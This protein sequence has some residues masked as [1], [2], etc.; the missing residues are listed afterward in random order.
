MKSALVSMLGL[1]LVVAQTPNCSPVQYYSSNRGMCMAKKTIGAYCNFVQKCVDGSSCIG[2]KCT[3]GA[4]GAGGVVYE[5]SNANTGVCN[6]PFGT[7][8]PASCCTMLSA[9][10]TQGCVSA[11]YSDKCQPTGDPQKTDW[12]DCQTSGYYCDPVDGM[13]RGFFDCLVGCQRCESVTRAVSPGVCYRGLSGFFMTGSNNCAVCPKGTAAKG[14]GSCMPLI[15]RDLNLI[16]SE[17]RQPP[18]YRSAKGLL[19]VYLTFDIGTYEDAYF[20]CPDGARIY[21]DLTVAPTFVVFPGDML[22][23]HFMN[24]LEPDKEEAHV[25]HT[26]ILIGVNTTNLHVHGLHVSS[27]QPEDDVLIEIE[28][29]QSF[30]YKFIIHKDHMPGHHWYH[31]HRHGASALHTAHAFGS[32]VIETDYS[33]AGTKYGFTN[34]PQYLAGMRKL[35]FTMHTPQFEANR[36]DV[37]RNDYSIKFET[38]NNV[39]R[40]M[41]DNY[42]AKEIDAPLTPCNPKFPGA[43]RIPY[44]MVNGQHEPFIRMHTGEPVELMMLAAEWNTQHNVTIEGCTSFILSKDGIN[45]YDAPR[46]VRSSILPPGARSGTVIV[47]PQAGEYGIFDEQYE[48]PVLLATLKVVDRKIYSAKAPRVTAAM[49]TALS[50]LANR[51]PWYLE[52]LTTKPSASFKKN[53]LAYATADM[54]DTAN[55]MMSEYPWVLKEMMY[56]AY[57]DAASWGFT[58]QTTFMI[59]KVMFTTKAPQSSFKLDDIVETTLAGPLAHP[60]HQHVNPFQVMSVFPYPGTT[61]IDP[62]NYYDNWYKVKDWQ[63]T[64][65][66]ATL[67]DPIMGDSFY[68]A[69]IRWKVADFDNEVMVLHCH[70]LIHEDH[71]MMTWYAIG[72]PSAPNSDA[73]YVPHPQYDATTG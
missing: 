63:D 57:D 30:E 17:L 20:H 43:E 39:R 8:A 4:N 32:I 45:L 24:A 35:I 1:A 61:T 14:D 41:R 68:G 60:H 67:R 34:L 48:P 28:G 6:V 16:G 3:A 62:M 12:H 69:T 55:N 42:L 29:G 22:A 26:N 9:N 58:F 13:F 70:I 21:N 38:I 15:T 31:P 50:P 56:S 19:D 65:Q 66:M 53:T 23:I 25:N 33:S 51:W 47:C 72:D 36:D 2:N 73:D 64:F 40:I 52:D 10:K 7:A 71:G 11:P 5:Y 46:R 18:V 59:N 37:V 44:V 49:M 27:R 54:P